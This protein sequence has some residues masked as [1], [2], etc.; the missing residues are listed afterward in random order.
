MHVWKRL[1]AAKQLDHHPYE[2]TSGDNPTCSC[3]DFQR[4][5]YPCK[6]ILK[7]WI[8]SEGELDIP[9]TLSDP[10]W[11]IDESVMTIQ[12]KHANKPR[13]TSAAI[14]LQTQDSNKTANKDTG[15]IKMTGQKIRET[16]DYLRSESYECEELSVARDVL[17]K[18]EE[19]GRMMRDS[20]PK[21]S[22]LSLAAKP[23]C[24]TIKV[25]KKKR[26]RT[27]VTHHDSALKPKRQR[28]LKYLYKPGGQHRNKDY[29]VKDLKLCENASHMTA[30][31]QVI[32]PRTQTRIS[33]GHH[34]PMISNTNLLNPEN[35]L[36]KDDI[37]TALKILEQQWSSITTQD[38]TSSKFNCVVSCGFGDYCQVLERANGEWVAATN[39]PAKRH[40]I[41]YLDSSGQKMPKKVQKAIAG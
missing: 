20:K 41:R 25:N 9:N 11:S 16:L 35:A 4:H 23:T 33:P 8:T 15:S 3:E 17:S 39:H 19:I 1:A 2:I 31:Q 21:L 30:Q 7:Q 36:Q 37:N 29:V 26:K 27:T 32:T 22:G 24:S 6:H 5:S 13:N 28:P 34:T 18:L 40:V 12:D 14:S 10:W 38:C